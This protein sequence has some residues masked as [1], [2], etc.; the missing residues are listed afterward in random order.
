[1]SREAMKLALDALKRMKR[2]GNTFGYRSH[3]QNPYD[4]VCEAITA[5]EALAEQS[6]SCQCP[7][8]QKTLHASGCAVHNAPA[9]PVGKCD[10]GAQQEPVAEVQEVWADPSK[11]TV[12]VMHKCRVKVGDK[13]YTSPPAQSKP[14]TDEDLR[15]LADKHLFYQPEG[16]EVSGVFA[17]ARAIEAAHGI[18]GNT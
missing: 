5:L 10:C 8:C 7:A 2:Y 18:K 13:L 14:L 9:Y 12:I 3:E 1:M 11:A 15:K 16:Y 6:I 17:L 4:Q